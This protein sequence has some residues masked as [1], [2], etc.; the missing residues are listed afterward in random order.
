[1]DFEKRKASFV[2]AICLFYENGKNVLRI[3]RC[4]GYISF[5]PLGRNGFG[6]DP[7]FYIPEY[8]M[9]TAQMEGWVKQKLSH[10]GKAL[11]MIADL[12]YEQ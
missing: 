5:K 7:I 8:Y 10:R 4:D 9:T 1:V 2:C 11:E 6:Y 12:L 3:G